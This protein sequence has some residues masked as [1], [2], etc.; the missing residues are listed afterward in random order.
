MSQVLCPRQVFKL[1]NQM[2]GAYPDM[3]AV[4]KFL[5]SLWARYH[6]M[7]R[8]VSMAE[9]GRKRHA[10][11]DVLQIQHN[12]AT[13]SRWEDTRPM[14]GAYLGGAESAAPPPAWRG[15]EQTAG[16]NFF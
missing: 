4:L 13:A 2:G 11:A 3:L 9:E 1:Y 6:S 10:H 16:A 12:P 14:S 8:P 15:T 7:P 5:G